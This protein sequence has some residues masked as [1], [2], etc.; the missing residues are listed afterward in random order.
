MLVHR[1]P[2][3]VRRGVTAEAA[4]NIDRIGATLTRK[5][6]DRIGASLSTCA[7]RVL[8]ASVLLPLGWRGL[9]AA[10]QPR[11]PLHW[12]PSSHIG[13]RAHLSRCSPR[14]CVKPA[15]MASETEIRDFFLA[16]D[17][18]GDG[19]INQTT[20]LATV[21]AP[22]R[23]PS[24]VRTQ[25]RPAPLLPLF[26]LSGPRPPPSRVRLLPPR[27]APPAAAGQ[28]GRSRGGGAA[29]RVVGRLQPALHQL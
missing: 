4:R 27:F 9:R 10:L 20:D 16:L 26:R 11:E 28:G 15:K 14:P 12:A 3:V 21:S 17:T 25:P 29:A 6:V 24:N 1:P 8:A 13:T 23:D 19:W 22:R 5:T 18:D 2:W 7:T